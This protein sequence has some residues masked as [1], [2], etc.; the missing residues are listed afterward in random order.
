MA[1]KSEKKTRI[2][3]AELRTDCL[4]FVEIRKMSNGDSLGYSSWISI[5]G[6]RVNESDLAKFK[7]TI[8]DGKIEPNFYEQVNRALAEK[9]YYLSHT[10]LI[11]MSEK[12]RLERILT[13]DLY[14][15]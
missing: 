9:G 5:E 10:K 4:G 6:E 7:T 12:G 3:S 8:N 1:E 13:G 2:S 11:V 15:Y 14:R